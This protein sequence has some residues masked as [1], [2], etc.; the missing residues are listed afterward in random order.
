MEVI[1]GMRLKVIQDI[2][3]SKLWISSKQNNGDWD[4]W[5][6]MRLMYTEEWDSEWA[7]QNGKYHVE[8]H[9][10]SPT[11]VGEANLASAKASC[12]WKGMPN[13]PEALCEMLVEYGSSATLWQKTGNNQAVLLAE[14]RK[15][16]NQLGIMF[17][18]AMDRQMNAIGAT[19]WDFIA[20]DPTMRRDKRESA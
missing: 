20:G 3:S 12:D 18:F 10:V 13:V 7:K 17:G 6:I 1:R 14:C 16:L 9:A 4:Y 2:D 15:E 8:L 5:Y 19:G 11:A